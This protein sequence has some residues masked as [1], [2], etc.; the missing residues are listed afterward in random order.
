MTTRSGGAPAGLTRAL[1][2]AGA[3]VHLSNAAATREAL[4]LLAAGREEQP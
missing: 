2:A 1:A 4:A 3:V